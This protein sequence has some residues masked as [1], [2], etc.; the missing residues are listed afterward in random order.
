VFKPGFDILLQAMQSQ[1]E[2]RKSELLKEL[3]SHY[4]SKKM[5]MDVYHVKAKESM[6]NIQHVNI[7]IKYPQWQ[8]TARTRVNQYQMDCYKKCTEIMDWI[9][10]LTVK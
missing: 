3:D 2:N 10:A 9:C 8:G 4:N 6:E 5:A 1:I 7:G